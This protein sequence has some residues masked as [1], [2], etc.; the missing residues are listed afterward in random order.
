[1]QPA[2]EI[3]DAVNRPAG[4]LEQ[5]AGIRSRRLWSAEDPLAE[6]ADAGKEALSRA[7]LGMGD[8]AT[9]LVTSEAPPLLLGLA[10]AVHHRLGLTPGTAAVEV[11]G[12]CT[13]FLAALWLGR[14]L[15]AQT[16][17]VL[18][19][20]VEAPSRI[21]RLEPGPTGDLAALFGD[22]AAAC[23][24]TGRRS[25]AH[26]VPVIDVALG[27]D[28]S[29]AHLLSADARDGSFSMHMDG[30][31]LAGRAVR[32]MAD[33]SR[34]LL[35]QHGLSLADVQAVIAHG[36]NGRMPA[37][38]AR[39]LG[40]PPAQVWSETASAG[41]LGSATLPVAWAARKPPDGHVLW[42]AV[43]AGL[44]W[45]TALTGRLGP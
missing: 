27:A 14:H 35:K 1:V 42:T 4:W 32:V 23:V 13:G 16:G 8:V 2:S 29:A 3:D 41:N 7:G 34:A 33:R 11:G 19:I 43:G 12:A 15:L 37:L 36:G 22:G 28:G 45:A 17:P 21:L 5:H 10:A 26:S 40:I 39:K 30:Q 9:L 6:A 38:L 18:I 44:T 24:L 31:A 25:S 20:A